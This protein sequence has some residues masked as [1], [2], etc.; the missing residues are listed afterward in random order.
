MTMT[1]HQTVADLMT[2]PAVSV[3]EFCGIRQ[4]AAVLSAHGYN[5]VPVL[6]RTGRLVGIITEDDLVLRHDPRV[7][8]AARPWSD[9]RHDERE[10]ANGHVAR[11]IMS[12]NPVTISPLASALDAAELMHGHHLKC[13]PVVDVEGELLGMIAR[14]DLVRLYLRPDS[15]I[16]EELEQRLREE[17]FDPRM[18]ELTVEEGVA[19]F[20]GSVMRASDASRLRQTAEDVDGMAGVRVWVTAREL[21]VGD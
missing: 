14:S 12:P 15:E 2:V 3:D 8:A 5:G 7:L 1:S 13:L 17:S 11:E 19:T 9:R 18:V 21:L 10:R 16:Q 4:V 6:S 20:T